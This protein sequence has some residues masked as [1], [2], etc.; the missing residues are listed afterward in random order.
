MSKVKAVLAL[1]GLGIAS[2]LIYASTKPNTFE[3]SRSIKVK[4]QPEKIFQLV[5]DLRQWPRWSPY[6]KLDPNMKKTPSGPPAGV[7]AASAWDGEKA[8]AGKM[9]I[10]AS[11]PFTSI[12]MKLDMY[13]PME[14]TN[15]VNFTFQS[16]GE[17]TNV[18]WA[19]SGNNNFVG[20]L[21]SV[22]VDCDKMMGDDFES[23]LASLKEV[24]EGT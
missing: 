20:K 7:G 3:Y 1:I 4:A 13:K 10:T 22:F 6:E 14:S 5:N 18:T 21:F 24:A 16:E 2:I 23:G 19:M 9:E 17:W 15:Q 8:G 12:V 11:V